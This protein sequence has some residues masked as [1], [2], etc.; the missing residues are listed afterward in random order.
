MLVTPNRNGSE[1]AA[2]YR[3]MDALG[4]VANVPV[5]NSCEFAMEIAPEAREPNSD[6][7]EDDP[8][9][10]DDATVMS[11]LPSSPPIPKL[12]DAD[13]VTVTDERL[14]TDELDSAPPM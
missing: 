9:S 8:T 1:V 12:Y 4:E 6:M 13:A 7:I 11:E 2:L 3:R 14:I 5:T 10:V